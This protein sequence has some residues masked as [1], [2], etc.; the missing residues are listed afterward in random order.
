M[1]TVLIAPGG[2]CCKFGSPTLPQ[3]RNGTILAAGGQAHRCRVAQWSRRCH[4]IALPQVPGGSSCPLVGS[5]L[6]M[7]SSC[8]ELQTLG[9]HLTE[10]FRSILP[11]P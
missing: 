6:E 8:S 5:A 1:G 11:W 4:H 9:R 7:R 10:N 3:L 2:E